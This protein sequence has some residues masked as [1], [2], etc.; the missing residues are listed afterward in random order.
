[1]R[2]KL[3]SLVCTSLLALSTFACSGGG[4]KNSNDRIP[5]G[6]EDFTPPPTNNGEGRPS[7]AT[8]FTCEVAEDCGYWHCRCDDGFVVNTANCTNGYCLDASSTCPEAC[9]YFDHGGWT[10]EYG[11]GPRQPDDPPNSECG[12][13]EGTN[14]TCWSCVED[15]CCGES[16]ACYDNPQCLGY[17]DCIVDCAPDDFSC[18]SICADLYSE[19]VNDFYTVR[20]CLN[21]RC[22]VEC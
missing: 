9:E 1:M 2:T 15:E 6:E 10:G 5:P 4:G 22:D 17:W 16:A 7:G 20:E 18:E 3:S 13:Q 21:S 8:T 14:D 11:G 12:Q 19:G